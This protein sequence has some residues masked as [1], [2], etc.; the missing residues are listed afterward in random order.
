MDETIDSI[1]YSDTEGMNALRITF[2]SFEYYSHNDMLC[3]LF[4]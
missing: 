3:M 1:K 4:V 2:R